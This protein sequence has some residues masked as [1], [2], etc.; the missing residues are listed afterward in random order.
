MLFNSHTWIAQFAK[1]CFRFTFAQLCQMPSRSPE[2]RRKP[3]LRRE[4]HGLGPYILFLSWPPTIIPS[5]FICII[6]SI[7]FPYTRC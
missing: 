1:I 2:K 4:I 3:T 5:E 6:L 7:T